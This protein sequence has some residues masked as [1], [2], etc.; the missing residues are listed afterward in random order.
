[1]YQK[2]DT[3]LNFV[4][5]EKKVEKF[6]NENRLEKVQKTGLTKIEIIT[7]A[8]IIEE[9]IATYP[10]TGVKVTAN[11]DNTTT[12]VTTTLVN[13]K[14]KIIYDAE[15]TEEDLQIVLDFVQYLEYLEKWDGKLPTVMTGSNGVEIII[16]GTDDSLNN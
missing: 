11:D 9:E 7:L 8:S 2:V 12:T 6:W 16:P 15:H 14:Y 5:R 13:T 1:M 10:I 3:N 4:E